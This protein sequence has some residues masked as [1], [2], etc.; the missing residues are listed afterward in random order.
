ML[1]L[2]LFS[3]SSFRY[4]SSESF[5]HSWMRAPRRNSTP[6]LTTLPAAGMRVARVDG[7]F[8]FDLIDTPRVS[9][10]SGGQGYRNGVELERE[11]ARMLEYGAVLTRCELLELSRKC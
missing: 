3:L 1:S 9:D 11:C 5:G 2:F 8:V 7:T 10:A 4:I 6:D